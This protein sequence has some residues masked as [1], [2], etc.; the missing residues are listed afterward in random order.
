MQSTLNPDSSADDIDLDDS[1][2]PESEESR[3]QALSWLIGA[4]IVVTMI[5]VALLF[6]TSWIKSQFSPGG[7]DRDVTVVIERGSSNADIADQLD[8][9]GIIRSSGFFQ[10][11]IQFKGA[12]PF[13]AGTYNF[14]APQNMVDVIR[15]LEAGPTVDVTRLTIPEG[16][17]LD[18]IAERV[19]QLPGRNKQSFLDVARSGT[20][21]SKYQPVGQTS[22]E[23]ML[24]PDTYFIST[25]EN[26]EALLRRMVTRFDEVLDEIAFNDAAAAAGI[27]PYDAII[28]ASMIERE[29][30]IDDERVIISG[31][32]ANRLRDGMRLQLDATVQYA[33]GGKAPTTEDLRNNTSP[34]NTYRIDG[35]P[36]T[37]IAVSGKSSLLASVNPASHGFFFYV[38]SD[39][40]GRH[41]FSAT[42]AEQEANIAIARK[43]GLL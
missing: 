40:D 41:A 36:P 18:Q 28:I 22:L 8:E 23:G 9:S 2:D 37:P 6:S 27:S 19:G 25:S 4:G 1:F 16:F 12:K 17:T 26:E 34:Y 42:F 13:Q 21:R 24:F 32:I 29:A 11:Y 14:R 33:L 31:V 30:K 20:V 15:Q 43:K 7:D 5:V 3:H 35:L 10:A 38:L 39:E